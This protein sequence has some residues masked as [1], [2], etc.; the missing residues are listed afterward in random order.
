MRGEDDRGAAAGALCLGCRRIAGHL[1]GRA[2][3]GLEELKL[4]IGYELDGETIDI[5]PLG[6]DEIERCQP[7]YETMQG[8]SESTVGVT[9]F[10][11]LPINARLYLQRIEQVT[12]VPID[13]ISTSPDRDHTS[14]ISCTASST[15]SWPSRRRA[16]AGMLR[17][18]GVVAAPVVVQGMQAV[19]LA[20]GQ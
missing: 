11:R 3:A 16:I 1:G 4:C 13:L 9:Q 5:L 8:W 15:S 19:Q 17:G 20:G 2:L 14:R 12:G 10:D 7:I 18:G 6:A